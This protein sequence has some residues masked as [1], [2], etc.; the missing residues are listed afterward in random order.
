MDDFDIEYIRK[1]HAL[2]LIKILEQHYEI[3]SNWEGKIFSGIELE[4]NYTE[5]HYRRTCRI[6]M[7]GYIAKFLIK[8]VHPLPHNPQLSPHKHHEVTFGTKEQLTPER[9]M[10]PALD[11]QGTKC[12]QSIVGALLYDAK[13]VD[14]KLRVGL[15]VIGAQQA[16]ATQRTNEAINQLHDYS[17]TYPTDG[18]L[19][20][21]S[22]M[23]ICAHSDAGFQNESKGRIIAGAH[24]FLSK[25][26]PMPEWNGP[27][28]TLSQIIKCIVSS[29]SDVE[30]GA[31]FVTAQ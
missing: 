30:L 28:L 26:D 24:V 23:M 3:I 10:S 5:Q 2:H 8:Y 14:N 19:Y 17:F 20:H 4:L 21:S 27:V 15:S 1:Q 25:N 7:N 22:D 11:N 6:S 13:A 9:Y 12:I 31:I 16:A 29:D 18:I